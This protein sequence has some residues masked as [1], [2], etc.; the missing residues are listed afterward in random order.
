[1]YNSLDFCLLII[2]LNIE[3]CH[4]RAFVAVETMSQKKPVK[5]KHLTGDEEL[6]GVIH[7]SKLTTKDEHVIQLSDK[8]YQTLLL[9][10]DQNTEFLLDDKRVLI[11]NEMHLSI[12]RS[13]ILRYC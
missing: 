3:H 10:L 2:I 13:T 8:S 6:R 11:L 4:I 7:N 12:C 5:R 9:Y 1:M